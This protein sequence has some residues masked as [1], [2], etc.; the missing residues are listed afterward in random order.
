MIAHANPKVA[1]RPNVLSGPAIFHIACPAHL[2]QPKFA[3]GIV[4]QSGFENGIGQCDLVTDGRGPRAQFVIVAQ[5]IRQRRQPA[6]LLQHFFRGRDRRSQSEA[7][8]ALHG[9]GQQHASG[10]VGT[11][12]ERL[13]LRAECPPGDTAVKCRH[14]ADCGILERRHHSPQII[15]RYHDV[16]VVDDDVLIA[17]LRQHLRQI[18]DLAVQAEAFRA[19]NHAQGLPGKFLLQLFDQR[20]RRLCGIVHAEEHFVLGILE[21][22]S[23]LRTPRTYAGQCP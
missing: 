3:E 2:V 4:G 20:Q 15:G 14:H 21:R 8:A 7:N 6:N 5:V 12:A 23:G 16:A 13:Q 19:V 18:A 17:R 22:R 10:K 9:A 11:Q 1:I